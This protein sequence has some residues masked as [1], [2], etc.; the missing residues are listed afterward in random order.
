MTNEARLV[1]PMLDGEPRI[2]PLDA[3]IFPAPATSRG[4]VRFVNIQPDR[5]ERAWVCGRVPGARPAQPDAAPPNST[6]EEAAVGPAQRVWTVGPCAAEYP[7]GPCPDEGTVLIEGLDGRRRGFCIGC[8]VD[9]VAGGGIP[10]PLDADTPLAV[11]MRAPEPD[12]AERRLYDGVATWC[13]TSQDLHSGSHTWQVGLERHGDILQP[14]DPD[15]MACPECGAPGQRVSEI[16]SW[17]QPTT[18][19]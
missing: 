3:A 4:F 9:A 14:E 2:V 17:D 8:A 10:V 19:R 1:A 18:R 6:T 16:R 12:P 11:L 15:D 7:S 13:C 5:K